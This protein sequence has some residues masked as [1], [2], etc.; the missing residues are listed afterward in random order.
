MSFKARSNKGSK[1]E[2]GRFEILARL[3]RSST[4]F[5]VGQGRYVTASTGEYL[6]IFD[7]QM[8]NR[9]HRQLRKVKTSVDCAS[10]LA[11]LPLDAVS[12]YLTKHLL[13]SQFRSML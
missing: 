9:H 8:L 1:R 12:F 7:F 5:N 11:Y 13:A 4:P 6:L 2:S 3:A 10:F